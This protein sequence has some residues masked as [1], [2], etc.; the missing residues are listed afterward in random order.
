VHGGLLC[1]LCAGQTP[2]FCFQCP[3]TTCGM[4]LHRG[5]SRASPAETAREDQRRSDCWHQFQPRVERR[6]PGVS[7]LQARAVS[8]EACRWQPFQFP[9]VWWVSDVLQ[10]ELCRAL[11][12]SAARDCG[13]ATSLRRF[14][15][16]GRAGRGDRKD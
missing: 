4:C 7:T 2:N 11:S 14:S 13:R 9:R 10:G 15:R 8:C 1:G 6:L 5:S 3:G 16:A 12:D